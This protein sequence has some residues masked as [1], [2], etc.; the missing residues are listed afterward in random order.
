MQAVILAANASE[1][2]Q[3]FTET[4]AKPMLWV[5]GDFVLS[6]T[7]HQLREA[8]VRE[9]ILVV[10]HCEAEIRNHFKS[11]AAWGLTIRYVLQ[12]EIK[13]IGHALLCCQQ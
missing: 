6:H 12:P 13:G 11:G 10:N 4:R 1:R 8:G 2:L 7:L 9:I 5:G 3:P